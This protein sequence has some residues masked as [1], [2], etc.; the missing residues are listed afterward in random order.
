VFHY[1][2]LIWDSTSAE[3][4]AA[5]REMELLL[6][7]RCSTHWSC[8]LR[9][10]GVAVFHAGARV[11]SS[12][13]YRSE[14]QPLLVLGKLFER[15][16][17]DG[18][19]PASAAINSTTS[20]LIVESSARKLVQ[21][22]WGRYVAF[23]HDR[24]TGTTRVLRDPSGCLPCFFTT[25][26]G[27]N[28][29]FARPQDCTSIGV[30]SFSVNWRFVSAFLAY[31]ALQIRKT[32]L[33]EVAE[34]Q[35]GECIAFSGRGYTKD[36]YWRPLEVASTNLIEDAADAV[37]ALRATTRACIH[38][39]AS[40][41]PS[42]VHTLSGGLDS[43][44]VASCL[45][46]APNRPAVTCL[47]YNTETSEGDER[48]FARLAAQRSGFH[49]VEK[50]TDPR[51]IDLR[52]VLNVAHSPRPWVYTYYL[53][54]SSFEMELARERNAAAIFTGAGGDQV[55]YQSLAIAGVND[56]VT[57]HGIGPG[58]MRV[59]W[60]AARMDG[61]SIWSILGEAIGQSLGHLKNSS[62]TCP[63]E[64]KSLLGGRVLEI[65]RTDDDLRTP[66]LIGSER[67]PAGKRDHIRIMCVPPAFY[68]PLL[69]NEFPERTF[70]LLSQPLIELCLRIPSHI[71]TSGGWDRAI[72]RRAFAA[73]VPREILRR[74]HKGS[75]TDHL[76]H[77]MQ[78]N[79][80]FIRELLLDGLLVRHELLDR[81]R[82]EEVLSDESAVAATAFEE[83][84]DY[85]ST[86]AWLRHWTDGHPQTSLQCGS[87]S[88]VA[89]E[90]A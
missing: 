81:H 35:P 3:T 58:L 51:S 78:S 88:T 67:V 87:V 40:C 86:E 31:R 79:I 74:R 90:V 11:G 42:I 69:P 64:A 38:A 62:Q 37:L 13:I 59:A 52:H 29:I 7:H 82:L 34:V 19:A 47:N 57:L 24:N 28:V 61:R 85:I 66:W 45:A 65:D 44:I 8:G 30:P 36:L 83:L 41:Y 60:N 21:H 55:F 15:Y 80:K 50:A 84:E 89:A 17:D 18:I 39:W 9:E 70:P 10:T 4:S 5:A 73:K 22:Y 54:H 27:V 48:R 2:G 46:D 49:L 43:S 32:G 76:K 20:A 63:Q 25:Y 72:A 56:Y 33:V 16:H 75:N 68:D 6:L 14:G 71:L 77:L 26:R 12:D 1:I 53:E 23:T